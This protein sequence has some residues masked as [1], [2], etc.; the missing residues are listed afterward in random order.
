MSTKKEDY[1]KAI[2]SLPEHMDDP[3]W[4]ALPAIT[5]YVKELE[6]KISDIGQQ[7]QR[8]QTTDVG[9]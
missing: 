9:H 4:L 1:K 5:T 6:A 8:Q 2:A 3:S 7:T